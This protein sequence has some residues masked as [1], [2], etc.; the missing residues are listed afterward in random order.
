MQD[1]TCVLAAADVFMFARQLKRA[2]FIHQGPGF[3]L[4]I[5]LYTDIQCPA[6]VF[7]AQNQIVW[8]HVRKMPFIRA[9]MALCSLIAK[10][11]TDVAIVWRHARMV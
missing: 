10:N 4:T 3:T 8:K 6:S 7:N 5:F 2:N 11:A 9:K 1:L